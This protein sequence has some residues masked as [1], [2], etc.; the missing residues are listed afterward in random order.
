MFRCR[1]Y[2]FQFDIVRHFR[3]KLH[4]MTTEIEGYKIHYEKVGFGERKVLLLPGAL[5]KI[6]SKC[7]H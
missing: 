3:R 6:T 1:G 7:H 4:G 2:L 5:G